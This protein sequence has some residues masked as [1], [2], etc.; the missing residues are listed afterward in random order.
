MF[1][2]NGQYKPKESGKNA[3]DV[4]ALNV[5]RISQKKACKNN[6]IG[7]DQYQRDTLFNNVK[8]KGFDPSK[9]TKKVET[10]CSALVRV[11][12][13]YAYGKDIAGNIR[14]ISEPDMLV[15]TGEFEKLTALFNFSYEEKYYEL[16]VPSGTYKLVLDSDWESFSGST[17]REKKVYTARNGKL[18]IKLPPY[19]AKYLISN[20]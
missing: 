15:K 14:T 16:N 11:C 4:D 10:D 7:Y 3:G 5:N 2:L 1:S 8:D 20:Y 12:I 17:R 6:D 9:T 18:K 13:A 19:S